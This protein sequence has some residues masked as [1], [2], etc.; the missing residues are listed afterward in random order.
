MSTQQ[1][2]LVSFI[3]SF[4]SN[5]AHFNSN[6]ALMLSYNQMISACLHDAITAEVHSLKVNRKCDVNGEETLLFCEI[7][8]HSQAYIHSINATKA[9]VSV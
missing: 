1:R 5:D 2:P 6:I 4:H 9:D 8:D 7:K 3:H